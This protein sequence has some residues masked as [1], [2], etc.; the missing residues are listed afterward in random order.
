MIEVD[1]VV[2]T[3]NDKLKKLQ[4]AALKVVCDYDDT[5]CESCGV[6]SKEYIDIL[7]DILI[8]QEVI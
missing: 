1:P 6:V 3:L 4:Q 8:D 2:Q 7:S 5:G